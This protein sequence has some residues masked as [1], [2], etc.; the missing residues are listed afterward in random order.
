M[1]AQDFDPTLASWLSEGPEKGPGEG[2][3][4]ALAATRTARQRPAW[5]IPA[6][7]FPVTAK[8]RTDRRRV[9]WLL[10]A[11]LVAIALAVAIAAVGSQRNPPRPV[12]PAANGLVGYVDDQ[13][14][15]VGTLDRT[16]LRKLSGAVE[17]ARSPEFSPDGRLVAFVSSRTIDV[18]GGPLYIVPADGSRPPIEVSGPLTVRRQ[19]YPALAWSP[20]GAY[21]AYASADPG[22]T[23]IVVAATD[24][25]GAHRITDRKAIRDMPSWSPDGSYIAYRIEQ[26]DRSSR[27][28]AVARADGTGERILATVTGTESSLSRPAWS[29]DGTRISAYKEELGTSEAII[30]DLNGHATP[31]WRGTAAIWDG[32]A[33]AWSPD[34][35]SIGL[36]TDSGIVV[37]G[38]DGAERS[39]LGFAYCWLKWSPD[40]SAVFGP[41][42]DRCGENVRVVP[43]AHPELATSEHT[44]MISWQRAP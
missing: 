32:S 42:G 38:V 25:S 31:L 36:L 2:L 15:F 37:A 20:D 35:R 10:V 33:A 13:G 3:E 4:R 1:T 41:Q 8:S 43:L 39:G 23:A 26:F 14:L 28:L 30:V 19:S 21:I 24:G 34:G 5:M 18:T 16:Q 27:S 44:G 7:S 17:N 6:S 29:P 11:A 22:I 12:G 9:A 40:G